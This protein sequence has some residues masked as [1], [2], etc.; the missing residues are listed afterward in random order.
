MEYFIENIL[1]HFLS[2]ALTYNYSLIRAEMQTRKL[3]KSYG[4]ERQ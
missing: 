3:T 1:L 4:Y 2:L